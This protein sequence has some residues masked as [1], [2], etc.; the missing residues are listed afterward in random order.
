M[1]LFRVCCCVLRHRKAITFC[2]GGCACLVACA[3]NSLSLSLLEGEKVGGRREME[4]DEGGEEG[5]GDEGGEE[6][7]GGEGGEGGR[8]EEEDGAEINA[9]YQDNHTTSSCAADTIVQSDINSGMVV[10]VV[11]GGCCT[12]QLANR[13]GCDL[14][15]DMMRPL[16]LVD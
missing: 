9:N 7:K 6:G 1:P 2:A 16:L 13:L 4:G 3:L 15:N 10:V 12:A 14:R 11:V 5:K 8:E